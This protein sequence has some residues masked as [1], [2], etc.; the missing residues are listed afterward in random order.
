MEKYTI[1]FF[2]LALPLISS[3]QNIISPFLLEQQSERRQSVI[4]EQ[5]MPVADGR[6]PVSFKQAPLVPLDRDATCFPIDILQV[7]ST[8]KTALPKRFVQSVSEVLISEGA[9]H[10]RKG[11]NEF[12]LY[13]RP[14][15]TGEQQQAPCLTANKI[16]RITTK[17]QNQLVIKGFITSRVLVPGQNLS[18]GRLILG[19]SAGRVGK[20]YI[21]GKKDTE[22]QM[23][24]TTLYNAF[25]TRTGKL[26]NL[27]D[28]E[29]GLENLRRLPTVSSEM[30]IKP[31]EVANSSDISVRWKQQKNPFR[32]DFSIDDSGSEATGKYLGTIGVSWDNPL[33]IN[34]ILS[35]SYTHSLVSGVKKTDRN[36]KKDKSKSYNYSL[37][38]NIPFGYWLLNTEMSNYSYDQVVAGVNHNYHYT[39]DTLK[40]TVD[41]SRTLYRDDKHKFTVKTAL[42]HKAT[43][44]YINDAEINVQRRKTSGWTLGISQRSYFELGT[45]SSSLAYKRGTRAFGAIS[46]PEELF[47]EGTAKMKILTADI[48]WHMPFHLGRQSFSWNS[49]FH[50]QWNKNRLTPQDK[51]S[52]GGRYSVR[53]FNGEKTLTGERG[54]F[55]RNSVSWHYKPAQQLYLALDMGRVSGYSSQYLPGKSL[56]GFALGLK[57]QFKK[58]GQWYYD[59]FV[60]SP[61]HQPE[62]FNADSVVAGFNFSYSL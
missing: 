36:G 61:V 51:I 27:R 8:D 20:L 39:G 7:V 41:I 37:N 34:D 3:A 62:Q 30:D 55:L 31:G 13:N 59:V 24:R 58:K 1:I 32:I 4:T 16:E 44:N 29:Q 54:W 57:G 60:G 19:V 25:P 35:A 10:K 50:G 23:E 12:S 11:R 6:I 56:A 45:L 26:L 14:S 28:F 43:K 42:W 18:K 49:N 47:N 22:N 46:A 53:G 9:I 21:E 5:Q 17:L 33:H 2:T 15:K 52:I 40:G 48:N 38:Y